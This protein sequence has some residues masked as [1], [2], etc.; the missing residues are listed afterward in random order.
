MN[1]STRDSYPNIIHVT[2][3]FSELDIASVSDIF[4]QCFA[5][6]VALPIRS[7]NMLNIFEELVLKFTALGNGNTAQIVD[8]SCLEPGIVFFIQNRLQQQGFIDERFALSKAGEELIRLWDAEITSY[9]TATVY[10]DRVNGDLLPFV[11]FEVPRYEQNGK[12]ENK[13][14]SFSFGPAGKSKKISGHRI[15]GENPPQKPEARDVARALRNFRRRVDRYAA[16]RNADYRVPSLSK[17]GAITVHENPE[18]VY[19]HCRLIFQ[20]G[21][22]ETFLVSDGFGLGYSESF[23]AYLRQQNWQWIIDAKEKGIIQNMTTSETDSGKKIVKISPV[24]SNIKYARNILNDW[25]NKPILG[26]EGKKKK[27]NIEKAAS[28]LYAALEHTFAAVVFEHPVDDWTRVYEK[29][30]YN[31][32]KKQV[33]GFAKKIGFDVT[34]KNQKNLEASPGKIRSIKSGVV[35][36]QPLL[37]LAI[38]GA[39]YESSHP[40]NELAAVFPDFLDFV[41]TLQKIRNPL[42]HGASVEKLD[43]VELENIMTQCEQIIHILL[44]HGLPDEDKIDKREGTVVFTDYN[45]QYLKATISLEKRFGIQTLHLMKRDMRDLLYKIELPQYDA[46]TLVLNCASVLQTLLYDIQGG[47]NIFTMPVL[48]SNIKAYACERAARFSLI[49]DGMLLPPS[50]DTANELRVRYATQGAKMSLQA[51]CVALLAVCDDATLTQIAKK[52][53]ELL[54]LVEEVA[55]LRGHGNM[56]IVVDMDTLDKLKENVFNTVKNLLE[57]TNEQ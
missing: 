53:P 49:N 37:A 30:Q 40:C 35:E 29:G 24:T 7:K 6:T 31:E 27:S 26:D 54:E 19:L 56:E 33:V 48:P 10:Q 57:V 38:T 45:Q 51:Q 20:R 16:L 44:P 41:I 50:L 43:L 17:S 52:T 46:Q 32:N 12:I 21:Y 9:R 15:T 28:D 36:L 23:S 13:F 11:N 1:V 22:A 8:F 39:C 4:W 5:Y 47:Q 42:D 18:L 55:R 34:E 3:Q 14:I 25:K 2:E